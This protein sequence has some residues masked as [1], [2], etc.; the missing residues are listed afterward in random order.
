[1]AMGQNTARHRGE[2]FLSLQKHKTLWPIP[3]GPI[4]VHWVPKPSHFGQLSLPSNCSTLFFLNALCPLILQSSPTI[5]QMA[6]VPSWLLCALTQHTD[7]T[8][9]RSGDRFSLGSWPSSVLRALTSTR[10][11][12]RYM[13]EVCSPE[14]SGSETLS[15][16]LHKAA[17]FCFAIPVSPALLHWGGEWVLSGVKHIPEN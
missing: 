1:M 2:W 16:R 14:D 10:A 8:L 11:G 6:L 12:T 4:W 13:V 15:I 9:C 7:V 3:P 5:S 17:G